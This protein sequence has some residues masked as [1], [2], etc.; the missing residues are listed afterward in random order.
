M[1]WD[2]KTH[3]SKIAL[4]NTSLLEDKEGLNKKD[5]IDLMYTHSNNNLQFYYS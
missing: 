3:F 1:F 4:K 5:K 2:R